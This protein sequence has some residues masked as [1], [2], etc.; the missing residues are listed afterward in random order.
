MKPLNDLFDKALKKAERVI[1][2]QQF[3]SNLLDKAFMKMGQASERLYDVQDQLSAMIRMVT[4]WLRR[5]YTEISPKALVALL[6]ALIYFVNPFDLISDFI[7]FIGMLDDIAVITYV[8][9]L[10][11]KEIERF[12]D[13]ENGQSTTGDH[14][15]R[16]QGQQA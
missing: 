2:D 1:E 10:F 3:I 12:M 14:A 8:V 6:A 7:P 4:A 11:N 5:D 13:W 15:N 16:A 9:N